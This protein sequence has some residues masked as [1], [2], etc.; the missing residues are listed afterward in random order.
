MA[1]G[2]LS[3]CARI[4]SAQ[5]RRRAQII[6]HSEIVV[7][8]EQVAWAWRRA[9]LHLSLPLSRHLHKPPYI[10]AA[11]CSSGQYHKQSAHGMARTWRKKEV[12]H[13]VAAKAAAW[14][15]RI[16]DENLL[17]AVPWRN[18]VLTSLLSRG[19]HVTYACRHERMCLCPACTHR[20]AHHFCTHSCT[21]LHPPPHPPHTHL[22]LPLPTLRTLD[23][24]YIP[25]T[26]F[27]SCIY[28]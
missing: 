24:H 28:L 17:S 20:T 11:R 5:Q 21:T 16:N 4:A 14:R 9:T 23:L 15:G 6:R 3:I 12:K 8:E 26:P 19:P 27:S 10:S 22:P 25:R 18:N 2:S 1:H 13:G 7:R